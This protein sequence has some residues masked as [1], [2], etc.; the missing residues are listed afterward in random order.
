M[1]IEI[2]WMEEWANSP[3]FVVSEAGWPRSDEPAWESKGHF[4][5]ADGDLFVRYFVVNPRNPTG[6]AG[7]TF[8]G[9]YKTGERFSF[10]GPWSSRAGCVNDTWPDRKVVD[11]DVREHHV[12]TAV[13]AQAV[14]DWWRANETDWG[15][16][17]VAYEGGGEP[18]LQPTRN[19]KLKDGTISRKAIVEHLSK[20]T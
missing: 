7:S 11:V 12:A 2:D 14:I 18:V 13:H 8:T 20:E 6:F 1:K 19:G 9:T 4:H 10:V 16:A 5:R 17:W 3:R 15:L